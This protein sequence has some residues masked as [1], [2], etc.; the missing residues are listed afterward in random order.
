[1]SRM[2]R[3][4]NKKLHSKQAQS[5]LTKKKRH[6]GIKWCLFL[7][8]LLLISATGYSVS[9]FMHGSQEAKSDSK[10]AHKKTE[11]FQGDDIVGDSI[12]IVL[13]G[14][15]SRGEDEGRSDSLMIAHYNKKTHIPKIVSIM[16]DTYANIPG[17]GY[18]KINA[19]YS[20]GGA[21]LTK[22]TIK[23]TF[24]IPIHY[25]AIA[26]FESFPKIINT[27]FPDGLEIDAEKDLDLDGVYI[28]KGEQRM[29]GEEVL[30]YARFRHD[31]ESD[32]G[33]VRRQQQVVKAVLHQ[34]LSADILNLPKALGEVEGYCDTNL[35]TSFYLTVSKALLTGGL[36]PIQTL[37]IPVDGSWQDGYYEDAGSVL[38]IDE[39]TNAQA[40]Q[41]FLN[42]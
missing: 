7:L 34:T 16:R 20:F 42:D 12:N 29:K 33:R 4:Q 17:Y 10:A 31:D 35:P 27:L 23:N 5:S 24:G 13:I 40:L 18:N 2:D 39:N 14:S 22:E 37:T 41:Q 15:D 38:E 8:L 32:F 30:Q 3:Y 1:M 28:H 21:E 9:A 36:K 19:A 26:D 11:N 6:R 25:Y